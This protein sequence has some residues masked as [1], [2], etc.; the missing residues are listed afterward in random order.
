MPRDTRFEATLY[1]AEWLQ[2]VYVTENRNAAQVALLIDCTRGAVLDALRRHGISI[3]NVSEAQKLA[4]HPGSMAPRPRAEF[5]DTLHNREWL[6]EYYVE[7]RK[8]KAKIAKL[9]GCSATTVGQALNRLGIEREETSPDLTPT[10]PLRGFRATKD[11]ET[12]QVMYARARRLVP[13]GPCVV[14]GKVGKHINHK[15]RNPWNNSLEN[16]ERVCVKCHNQQHSMEERVM[17]EWLRE[18]FGVAFME[19]HLE[20]RLRLRSR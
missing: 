2:R 4:A 6:I 7:R 18:R 12:Q 3:K 19:I 13:P 16:L 15:D 8:S 11:E 14:C 1:N 5:K 10:S 17:I 9:A 20:A